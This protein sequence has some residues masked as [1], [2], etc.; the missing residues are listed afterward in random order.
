MQAYHEWLPIRD[1]AGEDQKKIY[2]SFKFGNLLKLIMLETRLIARSLQ[3]E[4]TTDPGFSDTSRHIVGTEQLDWIKSQLSDNSVSW[5]MLGNQVPIAQLQAGPI[6]LFGFDKWEGYPAEKSSLIKYLKDNAIPNVVVITGDVHS[7]YG[8]DLPENPYS[9][10]DYNPLTGSGSLGVEFIGTSVTSKADP[11]NDL[12]KYGMDLLSALQQLGNGHLKFIQE[13]YSGYNIL[14]V[15]PEKVQCDYYHIDSRMT[16]NTQ[17]TLDA[18]WMSAVGTNHL[19]KASSKIPDY[20]VS[21][22]PAPV[23]PAGT[24]GIN[25]GSFFAQNVSVYPNPSNGTTTIDFVLDKAASVS[26]KLYDRNG[27]M[28]YTAIPSTPFAAGTH[29][30]KLDLSNLAEGHYFCELSAH[31]SSKVVK[32]M[33]VK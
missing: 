15:T 19:V 27:R 18:S 2:R 22:A 7:S 16:K 13:N 8:F 20:P 32:I 25:Q 9:I 28:V 3:L 23:R 29:Q 11:A 31:T 5:R 4:A 17:Q 1:K 30:Q 33:L 10:L 12:E 21:A 6:S 14:V 26:I 24:T